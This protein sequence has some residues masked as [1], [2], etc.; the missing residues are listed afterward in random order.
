[1]TKSTAVQSWNEEE[2]AM[3]GSIQ[4]HVV[5]HWELGLVDP[6]THGPWR[7]EAGEKERTQETEVSWWWDLQAERG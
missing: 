3:E 5:Q 2:E 4:R 1:M 6:G 7:L